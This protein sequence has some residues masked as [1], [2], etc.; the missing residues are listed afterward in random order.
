MAIYPGTSSS[1]QPKLIMLLG[2]TFDCDDKDS[3]NRMQRVHS[4]LRC[5]LFS[6]RNLNFDAKVECD[7][8]TEIKNSIAFSIAR[9]NSP[10]T[11]INKWEKFFLKKNSA[12]DNYLFNRTFNRILACFSAFSAVVIHMI[13]DPF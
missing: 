1:L 8:A 9:A 12:I 4:L 11:P 2:E 3:A 6:Q 7:D 5:S 10:Q 13:Y